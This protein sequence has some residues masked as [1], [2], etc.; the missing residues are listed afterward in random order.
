MRDDEQKLKA[1]QQSGRKDTAKDLEHDGQLKAASKRGHPDDGKNDPQDQ[2]RV[3]DRK[4][5]R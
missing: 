4:P 5:P 1:T 3:D 2:R